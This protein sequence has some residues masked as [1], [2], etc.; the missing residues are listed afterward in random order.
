[1]NR[2]PASLRDWQ[3]TLTDAIFLQPDES[4]S[5]CQA[6]EIYRNNL[7]M[8]AARALTV[9]YPVVT[10]MI[11]EETMIPLASRLLQQELPDSGDWADWGEELALLINQSELNSQ[12]PMLA[13]M[14]KFEWLLHSVGRS[15]ERSF[16]SST[17]ELLSSH[18]LDQIVVKAPLSLEVFKSSFP[19]S[20]L[21][22]LHRPY[23]PDY[24]PER[25][26][27][28]L[29]LRTGKPDCLALAQRNGHSI[30]T[31]LEEAEYE[32]MIELFCGTS[33]GGV[34]DKIPGFDFTQWLPKAIHN[35]W[36]TALIPLNETLTLKGEKP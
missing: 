19:V 9:S 21:W 13:D 4:M 1:M 25:E 6:L 11:G 33:I 36:I 12:I 14:A 31:P 7:R 29:T 18:D 2:I 23:E 22:A 5:H 20:G 27:I 26:D 34:L 35:G 16:I 15:Q 8:T 24:M 30:R 3:R 28:L 17:L 32:A 10:K